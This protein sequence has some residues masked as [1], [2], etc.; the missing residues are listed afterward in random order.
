MKKDKYTILL[1]GKDE[2]LYIQYNSSAKKLVIK[3]LQSYK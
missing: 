2:S 3:M 1:H